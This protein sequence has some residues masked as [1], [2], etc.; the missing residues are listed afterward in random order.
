M[1]RLPRINLDRVQ[2][3]AD[4]GIN[5]RSS[6]EAA[7]LLRDAKRAGFHYASFH[8]FDND[9]IREVRGEALKESFRK[10]FQH[11]G[12]LAPLLAEV[13][14]TERMGLC[15]TALSVSVIE[16]AMRFGRAMRVPL[17]RAPDQ[18][19]MMAW[20]QARGN[21]IGMYETMA[22]WPSANV[23]RMPLFVAPGHPARLEFYDP[24]WKSGNLR[25]RLGV[26]FHVADKDLFTRAAVVGSPMISLP[27]RPNDYTD[28]P[29]KAIAVDAATASS[30]L[31]E[32][33][34]AAEGKE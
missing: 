33:K 7:S 13:A 23:G 19:Y 22:T 24:Y 17:E 5:W 32:V 3:I 14:R 27:V 8:L 34:A 28:A 29:D 1:P 6:D 4:Y 21:A 25:G 16:D 12:R 18:R 30:W 9:Y 31:S 2:F 20:A 15:F 26:S 11:T 10:L